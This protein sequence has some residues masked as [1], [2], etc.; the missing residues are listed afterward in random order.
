MLKLSTILRLI[1]NFDLNLIEEMKNNIMLNGVGLFGT[2]ALTIFALINKEITVFYMLYLFWWQA[3]IEIF[4]KMI[5]EYRITHSLSKVYNIGKPGLFMMFIYLIFIVI[6]FGVAFT[7][8]NEDLFIVNAQVLAFQNIPFVLNLALFGVIAI[9]N[10]FSKSE[11][12]LINFG[13]FSP[14]MAILHISIILGAVV[15]FGVQ[16]YYPESFED[17]IYPYIFSAI[18]F[19]L[20]RTFFDWKML[21]DK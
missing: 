17:S 9:I 12:E 5:R 8:S 7:F 16:H 1:C 14:K 6:L 21:E 20:L 2:V 13:I 11:D 3:L 4:A 15:H 19:L 10:A 18:P